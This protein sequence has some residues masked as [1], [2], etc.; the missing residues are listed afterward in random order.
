MGAKAGD[1][2]SYRELAARDRMAG[3]WTEAE[4]HLT[5]AIAKAPADAS[6]Y[7]ER[8]TVNHALARY[9]AA[10]EDFQRAAKSG[11]FPDRCEY[12]VA[13]SHAKEGDKDSAIRAL[14]RSRKAGYPRIEDWSVEPDF[15]SLADD[16]RFRSLVAPR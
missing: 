9:A 11:Y 12:W 6:L 1:A 10:R 8:G 2:Q 15:T 16:P 3:R 13:R 5:Q 7:F 4:R 14:E